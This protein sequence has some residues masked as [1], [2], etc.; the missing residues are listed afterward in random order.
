[1]YSKNDYRYYLEH[2]CAES[3]NFLM[4]YGVKGM[5]WKDHKYV[6]QLNRLA[7]KAKKRVNNLSK[8]SRR[9]ASDV[10]FGKYDDG[11]N[12]VRGI[13]ISGK[14]KTVVFTRG[15]NRYTGG[16]AYRLDTYDSRTGELL[17]GRSLTKKTAWDSWQVGTKAGGIKKTGKKRL[18]SDVKDFKK[19]AKKAYNQ[20]KRKAKKAVHEL[21]WAVSNTKHEINKYRGTKRI[22]RAAEIAKVPRNALK[23]ELRKSAKFQAQDNSIK[24][25]KKK[26]SKTYAKYKK[27]ANATKRK[28]RKAYG[29]NK[30]D[31][32]RPANRAK[33]KKV[34]H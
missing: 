5:K 2:R 11:Q 33:L 16:K 7:Q 25:V 34:K 10:T 24:K 12:R 18:E 1:M 13:G 30:L 9:N 3:D 29:V 26:V 6:D 21:K 31:I 22:K 20:Q 8:H 28:A 4:H 17:K 23:K 27:A 15:K 14:K 19:K 32:Q